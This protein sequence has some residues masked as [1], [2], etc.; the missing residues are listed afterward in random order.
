MN[1]HKFRALIVEEESGGSFIRTVAERCL[2]DLPAGEVLVRVEYSSLNYKDALSAIGN[3]GVTKNYPHTPGID[4]AGI[5]V[6]SAVGEVSPG[7][8][9][10]VTSYDLGMNTPGGFGRYIRVPSSWVVPLPIGLTLKESMILGTAGLTAG[11]SV[12]KVVAAVSPDEGP[13]LV[14]GATGGV[15]SVAVAILAKLGYEVIAVSG[16]AD[17][18]AYLAKM[19]AREVIGRDQLG[20]REQGPLLKVRWAA[21][22]DTV[23]GEILA[24]AIKATKPGGLVTC[25]GNV[26]SAELDLTVYPF[27]LR[28]VTLAGIDSQGC[29]M[30]WRKKIWAKLADDW[31]LENMQSL[32]QVSSLEDLSG[33]IDAMLQGRLKGRILVDLTV[34]E[35]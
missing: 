6:E 17:A 26:A 15:G 19:G 13:V 34:M 30:A 2:A 16:K 11:L 7:D 28:G 1:A 33:H 24:A 21:V 8:S 25:C 14:T 9:V 4:A 18:K 5:V 22:V 27:I 23:G 31:K 10:I 29:P 32:C 12:A 3:R 20:V 35:K